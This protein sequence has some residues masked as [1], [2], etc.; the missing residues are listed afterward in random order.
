MSNDTLGAIVFMLT[1]I[2]AVLVLIVAPI[3]VLIE[4][5]LIPPIPP[6]DILFASGVN[7]VVLGAG[8]FLFSKLAGFMY[9]RL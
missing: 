5:G 3:V 6:L 4:I 9:K 8:I 2:I 1:L 7:V